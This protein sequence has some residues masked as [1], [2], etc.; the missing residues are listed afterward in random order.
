MTETK[1]YNQK[2]LSFDISTEV[3]MPKKTVWSD[4]NPFIDGPLFYT[5]ESKM[6][7]G[8]GAEVFCELL[9]IK[10]SYEFL[11]SCIVTHT[12]IFAIT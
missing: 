11:H 10:M 3:V 6:K 7:D 1:D 9:G 12:N 5:G 4:C 2:V 8:T